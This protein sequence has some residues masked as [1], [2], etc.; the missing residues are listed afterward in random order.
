MFRHK[1]AWI[2]DTS[3]ARASARPRGADVR[4]V[5]CYLCGAWTGGKVTPRR[6]TLAH[7]LFNIHRQD[8]T[9]NCLKTLR[10]AASMLRR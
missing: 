2:P 4:H 6:T 7:V 5:D 3:R 8:G 1:V 9:T 10:V